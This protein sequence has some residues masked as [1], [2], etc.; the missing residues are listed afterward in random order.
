MS[1]VKGHIRRRGKGSW[2]IVLDLGRDSAGKRR[3]KWHT[4]RGTKRDAQREMARLLHELNT[5]AY[6]EPTRITVGEYLARW[7]EDYARAKVAPKTFERY[8]EIIRLHLVPA[9]GGT[10]LAKLQ[11]LHVQRCYTEA[12][13]N[14]R[15][16]GV[17]GLSAQTVLHHHRVLREALGHA[18]RWQ[19]VGRNVADAVQPPRPERTEV[20]CLDEDAIIR[21]LDAARGSRLYLPIVL[22]VSTGMR[23]GEILGL[24]WQDVDLN[25]GVIAVRQAAQQTRAG[26]S[27]KPPKTAKGR[28]VV[29][30]LELTV[31][32][33][34]Q[35][36]VEQA[37]ERLL[38][39]PG[40]QD[41]GLVCAQPDGR[42]WRPDA[43]TNA[44][45]AFVRNAGLPR[46]RF[47]DLRHS[48]ATLLL[49]QGVHP[50]VV[51]ERL[52]HATVGIT[53]DTY[54]HVLPGMQEEAAH[55]LDIALRVASLKHRSI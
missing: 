33:L 9:L 6:V 54:S 3:Q 5:G 53:L 29:A 35:H 17:G 36:K 14:G 47:H 34:Q 23:R 4:V 20:Q 32:A 44:F 28:R 31:E 30:L 7:L 22:A 46:V 43:L 25:A 42:P 15:K 40:Y 24:R 26:I 49:R 19:L 52:G 13:K 45:A 37:K 38:L 27:F 18:V 39:G 41:H 50:K 16:D 1:G 12:L 48:H 11:P 51:S 10:P 2:A 8:A 55:K 21:L